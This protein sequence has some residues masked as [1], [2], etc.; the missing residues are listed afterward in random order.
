MK[1]DFCKMQAL[2][3]DFMVIDGV[4]QA[5]PL[6]PA[7]IKKW[8]DRRLGIGFD[9]LLLLEPATLTSAN[10][11]YRIFNANGTEVEQCGN[12]ARCVARFI[13]EQ[14]LSREKRLKLQT[15]RGPISTELMSLDTV[16]VGL[17]RPIIEATTQTLNVDGHNWEIGLLTVGNPHAI[18]QVQDIKTAPVGDL[19]PKIE[20]HPLFTNGVNV[21]FVQ[22][23]DRQQIKLR[24]WERGVGETPA[25][26]SG[27]CATVIMG[28]QWQQL[29]T[30][31]K[32][33]LPGGDLHVLH[34][35]EQTVYLVGPA[36]RVYYGSIIIDK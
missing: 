8:A 35:A 28:Q 4:R 24:V 3:N 22:I 19:G 9:Q 18:I 29:D 1:I 31:V 10:F 12:G 7:L 11:N 6:S 23:I 17:G 21:N 30:A 14:A 16:K 32:V 13:Y 25:C 33:A 34:Q 26:G 27:A 15:Q 20:T 5:I 2:G 36:E